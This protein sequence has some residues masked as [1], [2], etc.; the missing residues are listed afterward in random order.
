MESIAEAFYAAVAGIVLRGRGVNPQQV[1]A[2]L[3]RVQLYLEQVK[4]RWVE[5]AREYVAETNLRN[6]RTER[7][8]VPLTDLEREQIDGLWAFKVHKDTT[9]AKVFERNGWRE[10]KRR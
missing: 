8:Q 2:A 4:A 6:L 10:V 1:V 5:R 3:E 9:A 7:V